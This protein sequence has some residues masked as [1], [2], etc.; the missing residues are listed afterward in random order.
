MTKNAILPI[1][2]FPSSTAPKP[3][4]KTKIHV[5]KKK[6]KMNRDQPRYFSGVVVVVVVVVVIVVVVVVFEASSLSFC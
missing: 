4:K 5:G 6:L 1:F 2:L 3:V